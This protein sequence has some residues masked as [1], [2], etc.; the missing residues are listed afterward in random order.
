MSYNNNRDQQNSKKMSF[1]FATFFSSERKGN[2]FQLVKLGFYDNRLTFNFLKG[3]SGNGA[4]DGGEAYTAIEYETACLFKMFIDELIKTR[5]ISYRLR[6]HYDDV[7]TTYN[8]TFQD[9]DSHE[10]RS[11]G[12][13]TFKTIQN[14]DSGNNTVHLLYTNGTNDFDIALGSPYLSKAFTHTEETAFIDIDKNDARLYAL[15]YLF[16]NIIRSWPVLFQND[17]IVNIL[18]SRIMSMQ[19]KFTRNFDLLFN[20]LGIPSPRDASDSR[21]Q[22]NYRSKTSDNNGDDVPF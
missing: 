4:S 13:I 16:H 11:A 7:Y 6:T 1:S 10:T 15:G 8:I 12:N 2:E 9:K 5:V 20:K 21:Y 17:K 14:H 19:E 22:E 3:T 18:M